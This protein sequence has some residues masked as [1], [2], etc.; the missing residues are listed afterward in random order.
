MEVRIFERRAGTGLA[1]GLEE[2]AVHVDDAR[3]AGLLVEIIDVLRAEVEAVS[4][5]SVK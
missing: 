3:R 5:F 4:E 2:F 1:A